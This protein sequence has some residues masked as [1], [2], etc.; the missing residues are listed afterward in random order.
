MEN[1]FFMVIEIT[2]RERGA[3]LQ[4]GRFVRLSTRATFTW[5]GSVCSR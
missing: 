3:L 4:L 5:L 2:S 1:A